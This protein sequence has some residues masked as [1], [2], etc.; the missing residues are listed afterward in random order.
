MS[1]YMLLLRRE[2][3]AL[4]PATATAAMEKF[5]AWTRSLHERGVLRGTERLSAS[6]QGKTIRS[7]AG[8]LAVDGPYAE[9]K[10]VVVGFYLIEAESHD[11]A[12]AMA[13][14]CPVLALGGSVE[15]RQ[16][17]AFPKDGIRR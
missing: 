15:V 8:G 5:L 17:D 12:V 9:A 6:A 11:A 2:P 10:E 3:V 14:D 4:D 7:R 13:R 1:E 16:T